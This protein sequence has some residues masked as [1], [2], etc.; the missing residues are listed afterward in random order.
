MQRLVSLVPSVTETLSAWGRTPV[1]CTRFCER[2]DIAH[3]GGTKDP[4]IDLI[5]A[6]D[7][8][9]VIV[10][11]EENRRD[12][13]DELVRRG[14]P[15]H[16][17]QVRALD[18]V[19]RELSVLARLL[20]VDWRPAQLGAPM[21]PR[22]RGVVVIW[23]RPWMVLGTP[24]YGASLLAHLGVSVVTGSSGPYPTVS[25]DVVAACRADVVIAPSEP[26]PFRERHRAQLERI[27]PVTFV[28]GK[29]LFWWGVRTPDALARL[30]AQLA[31]G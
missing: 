31:P 6:M 19:A 30:G 28:D 20:D 11:T 7:P 25:L 12:D 27:A 13:F 3:V 1:A 4:S 15:V 2:D 14:V 10:D 9:L 17:L 18:D 16:V 5:V 21:A 8:D 23:R 29:D 26:Y 22:R 24:T